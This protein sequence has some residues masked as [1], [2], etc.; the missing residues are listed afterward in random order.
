MRLCCLRRPE[1]TLLYRIV[2]EYYPVFKAHPAA[3]GNAL[4]GY[5]AR[6]LQSLAI[7]DFDEFVDLLDDAG[8][9][10]D[11]GREEFAE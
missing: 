7:V 4:P 8:I 3:H 2:E 11:A 6:Q 9:A 10:A 1:H 5:C